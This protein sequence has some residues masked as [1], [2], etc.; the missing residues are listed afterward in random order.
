MLNV[1]NIKIAMAK[2]GYN[3][4]K[5]AEVSGLSETQVSKHLNGKH[6]SIQD[7]TLEKLSVALGIGK[8]KILKG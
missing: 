6:K 7:A 4:K 1:T 2:K 3:Q 8:E 5:L